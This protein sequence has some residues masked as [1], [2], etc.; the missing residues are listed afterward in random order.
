[1]LIFIKNPKMQGMILLNNGEIVTQKQTKKRSYVSLKSAPR[2]PGPQPLNT[3]RYL[4]T[5]GESRLVLITLG[6]HT[7]MC[8]EMEEVGFSLTTNSG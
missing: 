5:D 2:N 6:T 3:D 7:F 4:G 8:Y 1:M